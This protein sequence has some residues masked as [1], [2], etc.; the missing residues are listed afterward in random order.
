MK[1]QSVVRSRTSSLERE[2]FG[3]SNPRVVFLPFSEKLL[4]SAKGNTPCWQQQPQSSR[5]DSANYPVF[6]RAGDD[7]TGL[8]LVPFDQEL[9]SLRILKRGRWEPL[10]S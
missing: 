4:D 2:Q 3:D 5:S 10:S 1:P 7:G 9:M 8:T 6:D